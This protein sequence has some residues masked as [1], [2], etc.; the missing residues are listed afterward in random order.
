MLP[1]LRISTGKGFQCR[2]AASRG[3]KTFV[4]RRIVFQDLRDDGLASGLFAGELRVDAGNVEGAGTFDQQCYFDSAG[5][6]DRSVQ[7]PAGLRGRHVGRVHAAARVVAE[8]AQRNP[9]TALSAL[10]LVQVEVV[11]QLHVHRNRTTVFCRRHESDLS[12]G[13][14]R[15]LSKTVRKFRHR[16]DV[17]NLTGCREDCLDDY[18]SRDLILARRFGVLRFWFFQ[19]ARL[20]RDVFA[21]EYS[22]VIGAATSAARTAATFTPITAAGVA[23]I[24]RAVTAAV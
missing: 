7:W 14:N 8:G 22:V 20:R 13:G 10:H 18:R 6:R 4:H 5:G 17:R 2:G 11:L 9:R 24:T 15:L 19:D 16:D 23:T 12:R 3:A 1:A 21:A